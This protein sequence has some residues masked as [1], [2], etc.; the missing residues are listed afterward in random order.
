MQQRLRG[1]LQGVPVLRPELVFAAHFSL[2]VFLVSFS[3]QCVFFFLSN[4]VSDNAVM[5]DP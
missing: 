3:K 2:N 5:G 4:I 1:A